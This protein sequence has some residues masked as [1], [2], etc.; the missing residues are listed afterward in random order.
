MK[1]FITALLVAIFVALAMA[2]TN[3]HVEYKPIIVSYPKGTPYSEMDE[4]KAAIVKVKGQIT[5]EYKLFMGL[6][7]SVPADFVATIKTMGEDH[8]V[9][10][11]EDQILSINDQGNDNG[12]T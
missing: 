6:A 7:A 1:S 10:V 4:L 2:A 11:E 9:S 3:S 12:G 8:H 5:H